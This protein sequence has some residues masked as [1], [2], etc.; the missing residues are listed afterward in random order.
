MSNKDYIFVKV[1][2]GILQKIYHKNISHIK[3][4]GDYVRIYTEE[5]MHYIH[6]NLNQLHQCLPQDKF[7]RCHRS[8]VVNV[9]RIDVVEDNCIYIDKHLILIGEQ[10]KAGLLKAINYIYH[11]TNKERAVD[12]TAKDNVLQ[13]E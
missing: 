1:K 6:F 3:A 4:D 13:Y 11:I 7:C 5:K 8:F 2:A 12:C 10:F 9:D